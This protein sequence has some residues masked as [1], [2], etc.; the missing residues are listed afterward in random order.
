VRSS[1]APWLRGSLLL[2]FL[3]GC[4]STGIKPSV[5]PGRID[6]TGGSP[7]DTVPSAPEP[8]FSQDPR[9]AYQL[10]KMPLYSTGVPRFLESHPE[11]D[12]RGIL[13]GILDSGIDAAVPGLLTTSTGDRK[14]LDLRDFSG[15]GR[16]VLE[17]V[18]PRRD[19]VAAGGVTVGGFSR[20]VLFN[21]AGPWYAGV[22]RE[23][24]LGKAPAADLDA[25]GIVGDTLIVVVTRASD[26]WVLFTDTDRD[27][28]LAGER[29]IRDYLIGRET[30]GW[31]RKG[32]R[33]RLSV[34]ANLSG[35][36]G[37]PMLDLLFDTSGHGSH[38]AG[39]AAGNDMYQVPGFDGVAPG[40]QLL[41]LKIANN[42]QGGLSTSG[43]MIRAMDY[44][45]RFAARRRMPLVLNLS[46]AVGNEIEG[47]ARIDR[48]ID[49]VLA[50]HPELVLT[51]SGGNDGPGLSTIGF[52]S[53]ATLAL[54]VGAILPGDPGMDPRDEPVAY[55]SARGGEVA[56]PEV[57]APGT[58]YSTVPLWDRG[59][60]VKSG[61]SMASPHVAGLVALLLSG[62]QPKEQLPDAASIRQ[63]LM[64]TARPIPGATF[65]DQGSGIPDVSAAWRWLSNR[66]AGPS[67]TVTAGGGNGVT[68]AYRPDGLRGA[69]DT[70]QSFFLS[71]APGS[72][73]VT[74]ALR[75]NASW[76]IAPPSVA[77][78]DTLTEVVLRYRPDVIAKLGTVTGT[79][80]GWPADTMAGPAF[81]LVNT[82]A[83]SVPA[84]E[85]LAE[86]RAAAISAGVER[87]MLVVADSGQP[88]EASA[89]VGGRQPVLVF[90][91]EPNGMPLRGTEPQ[92]AGVGQEEVS[93]K[94]DGRD[95]VTGA[96]ELVAVAPPTQPSSVQFGVRRALDRFDAHRETTGVVARIENSGGSGDRQVRLGLIGG[97]RIVTVAGQG[98]DT[99]TTGFTVPTWATHLVVDLTMA[100]EQWGQFTDFGVVLFDSA[101][102]QVESAPLNYAVGRLEATF[103]MDHA[104]APVSLQL[105]PALAD[106]DSRATWKA[107]VAIRLYADDE[108]PLTAAPGGPS[109]P[110]EPE[111]V[112]FTM[113]PSPWPL[114]EEFYPLGLMVV[115]QKGETW[116]REVPLP[117]PDQR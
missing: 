110:H 19:S 65:V 96:Y 117:E 94:L 90:L 24:P 44:A 3:T 80:S 79:V 18:T 66:R 62:P 86:T 111:R 45:I 43:S 12:G 88:F 59:V 20:V 36:T 68:A 70:V 35:A 14:I 63:A 100:R 98:S 55:Y 107:S 67:I 64:V 9:I 83:F 114:A 8:R 112:V 109:A 51:V 22:L 93:F 39:I 47:G 77:L 73:P 60:E 2:V 61:T 99:I 89:R 11:S 21:S 87:R 57:V 85:A 41:G 105:F 50:A 58:A 33:P 72:P 4:A 76:L 69:G 53:S 23:L 84:T 34:A 104:A 74:F 49:S 16:V 30:F 1:C 32:G 17:R 75:S 46:F 37:A 78:T 95:V 108:L 56:K 6:P 116:T 28:S 48:L 26:G 113:P 5:D 42:A 7:P 15:E 82:V 27:G 31:A 81:R 103:D 38:V 52:P 71:R 106:P 97:E 101:G 92:I 13:I 29:P 25:N 54:T 115:K 102:A 91:H 10:Q 40:A